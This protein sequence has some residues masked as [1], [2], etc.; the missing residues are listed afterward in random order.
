MSHL[1][2]KRKLLG[3]GIKKTSF[4]EKEKEDDERTT[5]Q[6]PSEEQIIIIWKNLCDWVHQA[7]GFVHPSLKLTGH[8]PTRGLITTAP[9]PKGNLLIQIPPTCV[10]SGMHV[11][12][13]VAGS[14]TSPWL[15]CLGALLQVKKD[16]LS[17]SSTQQRKKLLLPN[18]TLRTSFTPYIN[19][20]PSRD[21]YETL[22]QWS[23]NDIQQFLGGT[24]LGKMLLLDR[25]EKNLEK[26][27]QVGVIPFLDH[28]GVLEMKKQHKR[29]KTTDNS[30]CLDELTKSS[31]YESFLEASMCIS[32]RGFHLMSDG[33]DDS[34]GLS[35]HHQS[36]HN[37][38]GPFL[39]PVIDLLNHDP[40]KACTTLQR[41]PSSG[42]FTMIAERTLIMGED[43]VHS[44]GKELTSAQLLQTFGFVP[45][46]H[47]M[48]LLNSTRGQQ[49][50]SPV[51]LHKIDHLIL[52]C[53]IVKNSVYPQEIQKLLM[54]R[55]N[56]DDHTEDEFWDV[57]DIPDRRMGD[58]IP[59]EIVISMTLQNAHGSLLSDDLVTLLAVQFLPD[60][61]FVE[62]FENEQ[63][64]TTTST[65]LDRSIV[66]DDPYLGMLICHS[67]LTALSIR[68]EEYTTIPPFS[69]ALVSKPPGRQGGEK[70]N[71]P[72]TTV[73]L[74]QQVESVR[75]DILGRLFALMTA[76]IS[77]TLLERREI[78]GRTVQA[79]ELV[80]LQALTKEVTGLVDKVY[81]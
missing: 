19:S 55:R 21:E 2:G 3:N 61:A 8:G 30:T 4:E 46:S 1:T 52:S 56:S 80:S 72:P 6:M 23:I 50:L 37:Y 15:R 40:A 27:Y 28:L 58:T 51:S 36:V 77:I 81:Q 71:K 79:E 24:T 49:C 66:E 13:K 12:S 63:D 73:S 32:T 33:D 18:A 54:Q 69:I 43:V 45:P 64:T 26:R 16:S 59:D 38:H 39:L 74:L 5:Q 78:C 9:I 17:S 10:I 67:L 62:I 11:P 70:T 65:R 75:N 76:K 48:Q 34:K 68:V 25:N 7:G 20:L 44:Y 60:D 31:N 57:Q 14:P 41:D 42:H 29:N 47:T 35:T 22:F 53:L